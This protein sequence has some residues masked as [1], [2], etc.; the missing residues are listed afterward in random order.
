VRGGGGGKKTHLLDHLVPEDVAAVEHLD[1]AHV[2]GARVACELDPGEGALADRLPELVRADPRLPRG[3]HPG[4]R[5]RIDQ[6]REI[7]GRGAAGR[8]SLWSG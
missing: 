4:G 7:K 1:G 8:G 5:W 2:A 3:R 6:R